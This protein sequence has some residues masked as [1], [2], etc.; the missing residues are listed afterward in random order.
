MGTFV[1]NNLINSIMDNS[2][3]TQV[4]F[5]QPYISNVFKNIQLN[6]YDIFFYSLPRKYYQQKCKERAD[7]YSTIVRV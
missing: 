2:I 1:T 5:V 6:V 4:G 3:A 7:L